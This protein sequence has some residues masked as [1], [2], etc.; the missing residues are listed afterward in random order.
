[1]RAAVRRGAVLEQEDGPAKC[2]AAAVLV[3]GDAELGLGPTRGEPVIDPEI[4]S[5]QSAIPRLQGNASRRNP[6]QRLRLPPVQRHEPYRLPLRSQN[7]T[8]ARGNGMIFHRKTAREREG[9]MRWKPLRVTAAALALG[10]PAL[11]AVAQQPNPNILVIMGD[12]IGYWNISAY[13]RGQMGY[14]TPHIDRIANEGAILT[15]YYG[16]QSCTAGRAAFITGQSPM[17]TGLLKVGLPGAK[18]GLSEKDPTLAELIKPLGYMTGQFGKNHLGDRW[19]CWYRLPSPSISMTLPSLRAA[20]TP[21]AAGR[22]EPIAP[23]SIGSRRFASLATTR[24]AA[25]RSAPPWRP[26]LVLFE[27]AGGYDSGPLYQVH[28]PVHHRDHSVAEAHLDEHAPNIAEHRRPV[29]GPANS[30]AAPSEARHHEMGRMMPGQIVD[31]RI[32]F[33]KAEFKITPTQETQWQQVEAA[34]R[35]NA[36]ALDPTITTARQNHARRRGPAP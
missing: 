24:A 10:L 32:A 4:G 33:L 13:N 30:T 26:Q 12:D 3:T 11:T 34:M 28:R 17:R 36:K 29:P 6:A 22:P 2:R 1:M 20:A 35:E 31:G 19:M 15:D 18:E 5:E 25:C 23:K 14:R 27:I 7:L 8:S 9:K 16:Q 21:I